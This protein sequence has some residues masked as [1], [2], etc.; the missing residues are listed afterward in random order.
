MECIVFSV[1]C[2]EQ[3]RRTCPPAREVC[4]PPV[5][6]EGALSLDSRRRRKD[7]VHGQGHGKRCRSLA[8]R[9]DA[10]T[11][12]PGV[13]ENA[14]SEKQRQITVTSGQAPCERDPDGS[15][16][17]REPVPAG[18]KCLR[19]AGC[20]KNCESTSTWVNGMAPCRG[21]GASTEVERSAARIGG[22]RQCP[23]CH[24]LPFRNRFQH[25]GV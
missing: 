16:S 1:P 8:R 4:P 18:L 13:A 23:A 6:K 21:A 10:R 14:A 25:R 3:K 2:S 9:F 15:N 17:L 5:G 11:Q 12:G 20:E 22:E 24:A 19:K 7:A